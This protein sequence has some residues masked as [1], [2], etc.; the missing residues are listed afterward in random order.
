MLFVAQTFAPNGSGS[1]DVAGTYLVVSIHLH[2]YFLM[3]STDAHR[4]HNIIV[5]PS[6]LCV[7][8]LAAPPDGNLLHLAPLSSVLCS[9]SS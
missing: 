1:G 2:I 6:S 3:K 4:M 9:S 7:I 5:T 8:W